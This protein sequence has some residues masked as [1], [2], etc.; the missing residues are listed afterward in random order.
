M[1]TTKCCTLP[2]SFCTFGVCATRGGGTQA[3]S[4]ALEAAT[5]ISRNRRRGYRRLIL[6]ETLY[7]SKRLFRD[8]LQRSVRIR[9]VGPVDVL[10]V[11]GERRG[12]K[13]RPKLD[14]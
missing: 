1:R 7:P 4:E 5:P 9:N 13:A 3:S 10:I 8:A 2:A 6:R 14:P 12:E 11:E